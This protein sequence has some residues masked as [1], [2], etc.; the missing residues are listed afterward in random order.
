M[1][2]RSTMFSLR[3]EVLAEDGTVLWEQIKNTIVEVL[4]AGFEDDGEDG[5]LNLTVRASDMDDCTGRRSIDFW[6]G[7]FTATKPMRRLV[8][9]IFQSLTRMDMFCAHGWAFPPEKTIDFRDTY[10]LDATTT[11]AITGTGV[12]IGGDRVV[13]DRDMLTITVDPDAAPEEPLEGRYGI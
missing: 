1:P 4:P 10:I 3:A 11:F 9:S 7:C 12:E 6:S 5:A 8:I 13:A 2:D